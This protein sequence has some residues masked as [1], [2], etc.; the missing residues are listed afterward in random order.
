MRSSKR[1]PWSPVLQNSLNV[2]N[3]DMLLTIGH[4]LR[5]RYDDILQEGVPARLSA[6]IERLDRTE[7]ESLR[8]SRC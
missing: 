8:D 1:A 4:A 2:S 3:D 6:L 5:A 7:S